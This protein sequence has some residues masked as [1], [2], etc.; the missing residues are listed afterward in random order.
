MERTLK[1]WYQW[2]NEE[3]NPP[4]ED[5]AKELE[6]AAIARIFE[7]YPQGH[8]QGELCA[9]VSGDNDQ[10]F[11]FRGWWQVTTGEDDED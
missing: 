8:T 1:I 2:R 6:E 5:Y 11:E 9:L 10:E 7:M 4:R 3:D